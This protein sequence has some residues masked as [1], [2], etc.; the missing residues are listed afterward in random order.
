MEKLLIMSKSLMRLV[1]LI[2]DFGRMTNAKVMVSTLIH[3]IIS[4]RECGSKI[5]LKARFPLSMLMVTF[6]RVIT[7]TEIE[8]VK[9]PSLMQIKLN[10]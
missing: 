6:T 8:T 3:T 1:A 7:R 2:L 9:A 4:M 10:M 5:E